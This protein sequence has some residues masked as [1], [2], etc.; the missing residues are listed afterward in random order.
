MTATDV[1]GRKFT[2]KFGLDSF[3]PEFY[4][5]NIFDI[6]TIFFCY[7]N[8]IL[9]KLHIRFI[10]GTERSDDMEKKV[11]GFGTRIGFELAAAGSAVG[12]GNIWGF[13]YKTSANGGAAYLVVY[14][15][16][17][18][19]IGAVAMRAEFR[20]G[21]HARANPVSAMKQI[22]PAFGCFGLLAV[23]IPVLIMCYYFVLGGCTVK[24]A[25]NSF[26][27][28]AG[29]FSQFTA[30]TGDVILHTVLFS[31]A[32]LAI[33]SAGVRG[34]IEK[35]SKILIPTMLVCLIVISCF[36]LM[37]GEGVEEGLAFFLKP[38]FSAL[39]W[40]GVLSAMGQAFFSLSLGCGAM[41][42]YG[43][44][45][46][47]NV[48]LVRSTAMICL[49]D[50]VITFMIGLAIFPALFHYTAVSGTPA[51]ELGMGGIGLVFITMPLVFEE[52]PYLG[53]CLSLLFFGLTAIAALTSVVSILEV[54]TQFVMQCYRVYR[55]HAALLI[56]AFCILFSVPV[57]LS[58]AG[59]L[60]GSSFLVFFG[61]NL[62]ELL[63]V[64]TNTLLMPLCAF[65]AC[66]AASW[67]LK[68]KLSVFSN[69]MM[70]F[71]TP[72]LILCP[73]L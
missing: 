7:Y 68:E 50:A 71:F 70:K 21:R 65:A 46:S 4:T 44:Y 39:T 35:S 5:D 17:I 43:S 8:L 25:L 33:V 20:I 56:T 57:G 66:L 9:Y 63:D 45:T 62:L 69:L 38:D 37:L 27:G 28:N 14:L 16:C 36:T 32:A 73:K 41:I 12:L 64:I 59:S 47:R 3:G 51:D 67:A 58:L 10:I 30:N 22:S 54:V 48:N 26:S 15:L 53:S 61:R 11:S 23:I 52:M 24:Y 1:T 34:G 49:I 40:Y 18:L 13:P 60:N 31:L 55:A 6:I 42:T 72:L 2:H 19:F 29:H